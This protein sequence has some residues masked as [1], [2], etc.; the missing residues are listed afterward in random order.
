VVE[1]K[2]ISMEIMLD[3]EYLILKHSGRPFTLKDLASIIHQVSAK[4]ETDSD[5]NNV[6][7]TTGHF[8]TGFI[9]AYLLSRVIY[10]EGVYHVEELNTYQ[11]FKLTLDRRG[12][13]D[14]I[15]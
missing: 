5:L 11:K 1:G 4:E 2:K 7:K 15:A 8:G 14:Q 9:L 13:I 3:D 12:S 6:S 10:L